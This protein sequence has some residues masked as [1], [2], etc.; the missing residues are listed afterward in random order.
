VSR[1]DGTPRS[2][3]GKGYKTFSPCLHRWVSGDI[4]PRLVLSSFRKISY[5]EAPNYPGQKEHFSKGE[6]KTFCIRRHFIC[7][8]LWKRGLL[9]DLVLLACSGP[10]PGY[11]YINPDDV[12]MW[13][14]R[15]VKCFMW[16]R[17]LSD[18][19]SLLPLLVLVCKAWQ[20]LEHLTSESS[21]G[22]DL[23]SAPTLNMYGEMIS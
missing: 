14:R 22:F 6:L 15:V 23:L 10:G 7:S 18:S 2:S 3:Q 9:F 13:A 1:S 5:G 11:Q 8:Q 16:E 20:H 17:S 21:I 4:T 12:N 19:W